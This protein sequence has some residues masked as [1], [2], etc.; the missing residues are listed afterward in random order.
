MFA[1]KIESERSCETD[2]LKPCGLTAGDISENN[3]CEY[4]CPCAPTGNRC[5][6]YFIQAQYSDRLMENLGLC[7]IK[8]T[9]VTEL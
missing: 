8:L 2:I 4:T 5:S 7:E 9:A 3:T 1:P 6:L